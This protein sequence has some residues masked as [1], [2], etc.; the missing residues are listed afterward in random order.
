VDPVA[1]V[2]RSDDDDG[3]AGRVDLGQHS[4]DESV[5]GFERRSEHRAEALPGRD[6]PVRVGPSQVRRLQ[7]HQRPPIARPSAPRRPEGVEGDVGVESDAERS[8]GVGPQQPP[9]HLAAGHHAVPVGQRHRRLPVE[10]V[11]RPVGQRLVGV[12]H[13]GPIDA[14]LGQRVAEAAD[15]GPPV[16]PLG[17]AP[18]GVGGQGDDGPGGRPAG[19]A[20]VGVARRPVLERLVGMEGQAVD[21]ED[22]GGGRARSNGGV[23][24]PRI[25]VTADR[26][27]GAAA[28][29]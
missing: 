18:E 14:R 26:P 7:Q 3:V 19:P 16:A 17:V 21:V 2:G 4:P 20:P 11:H 25:G 29:G 5:G 12:A 8:V 28:D 13:H 6:R 24:V 22:G 10:A 23:P 15:L 1:G 27:H 9:A